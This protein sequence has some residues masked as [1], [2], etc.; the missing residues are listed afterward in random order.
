LAADVARAV[1]S[2]RCESLTRWPGS[3]LTIVVREHEL[4]AYTDLAGQYPLYYARTAGRTVFGTDA[5]ATARAAGLPGNADPLMLAAHVC[6]PMPALV[7][8]RSVVGGVS[9][10]DGG[11]ALRVADDGKCR[12]WTY[13][14]LASNE[15]T[16]L[17]DGASALRSA[18]DGAVRERVRL[19]GRLTADFSGGHDSTSVAFL[20]VRHRAAPLRV[21]TYHHPDSP[22]GDLEYAQRYVS[23]DS[24]LRLEVVLGD[25]NTLTYRDLVARATDAPDPAAVSWPRTRLRLNRVAAHGAD[26]HLGG[27]GA[28]ALTV[29]PPAYLA[30][31]AGR[32][33][34]RRLAHDAGALA[35]QRHESPATVLAA[36][37]RLARTPI[38]SALRQFAMQLEHPADR[39][40]HW[41][42]AISWWP[43]PGVE[44]AWL[45]ASIRRQLADLAGATAESC[46]AAGLGVGE[47]VGL[48]ELWASAAV[49][50]QLGEAA[51]DHAVWP[52]SPFLDNDVVRACTAVPQHL[53]AEP[54]TVKPLLRQAMAGLVPDEVFTRRT[55]GN[56]SG[57]DHRGVRLAAAELTARVKRSRLADLG[58]IE[59]AAVIASLERLRAGGPIPI[60]ALN[61]LFGADLWLE[62]RAGAQP[63]AE[64]ASLCAR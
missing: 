42:D 11:H 26:V 21:F 17:T 54:A 30:G 9:R 51:R 19:S 60:P 3:Y 36:A 29:P 34:L 39:G 24:R 13:E 41:L 6:C 25:T 37:I 48:A 56:Y 47:Y 55:K 10:L 28:D 15:T 22:A 18:L 16:S 31:L 62:G 33:M 46:T 14:T 27:E 43:S 50:R 52:Q 58:V 5:G 49:Q 12:S 38:G 35:R 64:E 40:T 8:D 61:R 44:G 63:V 59:P 20:A 57:E 53:R 1:E 4:I 2:G 23:L 45:T 32:R 7:G